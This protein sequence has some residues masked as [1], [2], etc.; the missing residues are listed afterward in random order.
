MMYS[1]RLRVSSLNESEPYDVAR[2]LVSPAMTDVEL[3]T[4]ALAM[5]QCA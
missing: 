2:A 5:T 4:S 3:P 1:G